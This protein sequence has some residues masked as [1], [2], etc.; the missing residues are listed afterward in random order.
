MKK[1][2]TNMKTLVALLM[3]GAAVTSCSSDNEMDSP[4]APAGKTYTMT[5][6]ATKGGDATTRALT[7]AGSTLTATWATTENVYVKKDAT[8]A[9]GSLKPQADGAT[10]TLKGELSGVIIDENDVLTL[11]FPKSGDITYAGQ[12]GTLA[13]IAENF[14]WAIA[15][16]VLV[17]SVDGDGNITTDDVTFEHQQAIVRFT[18]VDKADGTTELSPTALTINDGT[19]DIVTL[20]SIPAE[21]YTTN[22]AGVLYVALP[23]VSNKPITLTATVGSDTYT[24]TTSSAKSFANGSFYRVTAK[25]AEEPEV[26]GSYFTANSSGLKVAFSQGNLQATTTDGGTH[27]TWAFAEHQWDY[28]GNATATANPSI[29][30][31]GTVSENGTVEFFCWSTASTY[32]GIHNSMNANTYSG[33][34]KDW[35]TLSIS[36]GGGYTWRTLTS[37][38]W[39]HIFNDRTSGATVNGTTDARY[40]HAT[41][42]TDGTAVNG[43]ILFPDGCKIKAGSATTW[44]TINGNSAWGTKCTKAQWS[45]LEELGCVFLPAAGSRHGSEANNVGTFGCYWSATPSPTYGTHAYLVEFSSNNYL[46]STLDYYRD[47]GRSVRLVREVAAPAPANKLLSAATAEDIGKVVGAGWVRGTVL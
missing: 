32:Y 33:D 29:T 12:K 47:H 37:A 24:L 34:F 16:D 35:G 40:A 17:A 25:M 2:M 20:T 5:V 31:N 28:V 11:Q 27:W 22:G 23:A 6:Q 10:A 7:D 9:T 1:M 43:I 46:N 36:N 38:E 4:K 42:N 19:S 8:W 21:T 45:H 26:A 41:I 44:G 13:D 30:G 15:E 39:K 14:D 18:L 3:A